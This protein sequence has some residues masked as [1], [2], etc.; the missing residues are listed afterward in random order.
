MRVSANDLFLPWWLVLWQ[1]TMLLVLWLLSLR[2][3][4]T[5]AR[6]VLPWLLV[7]VVVVMLV[8]ALEGIRAFAAA[9]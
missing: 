5:S 9:A 6:W 1:L 8:V 4:F 7:L 3:S 2:L